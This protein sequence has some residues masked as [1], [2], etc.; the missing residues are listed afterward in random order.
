V[1]FGATF[2]GALGATFLG[3]LGA[4]GAL[5]GIS[6]FSDNTHSD[7][8]NERAVFSKDQSVEFCKD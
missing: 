7:P 6:A 3:A 8:S 1:R 4:L 2:L 5:G